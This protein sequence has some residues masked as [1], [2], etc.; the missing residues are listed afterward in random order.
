MHTLERRKCYVAP[1]SLYI[2][3]TLQPVLPL[4]VKVL[5]DSNLLQSGL[6]KKIRIKNQWR[7]RKKSVNSIEYF[8]FR[9]SRGRLS[10]HAT[11]KGRKYFL[12][13]CQAIPVVGRSRTVIDKTGSIS[14]K[15]RHIAVITKTGSISR[16]K[17]LWH[18]RR[19]TVRNKAKQRCLFLIDLVMQL[20]VCMLVNKNL[21]SK[22]YFPLGM[23][24][25]TRKSVTF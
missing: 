1:F 2:N 21:R 18:V 25:T 5:I 11:R 10:R 6:C 15:K 23:T 9:S 24:I 12:E 8:R 20:N 22:F 7:K 17:K 14:W 4:T 19:I 16:K 3:Q 13:D